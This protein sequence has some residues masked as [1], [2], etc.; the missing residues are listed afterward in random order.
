MQRLVVAP[1][2]PAT[3]DA[4]AE[5]VA[6]AQE[7]DPLAPVTVVVP[8][9]PASVSVR[10]AL[11]RRSRTGLANVRVLALPQLAELLATTA[12]SASGRRPLTSTRSI[13]AV[14]AGLLEASPPLS[15]VPP[16]AAVEEALAATF[17][18]LRDA[19]EPELDALA[20]RSVRAASVVDRFRDHRRRVEGHLDRHDVLALAAAVARA[21]GQVV[22]ELGTVVLHLPRRLG[23]GDLDL[24]GAL[25]EAGRL[26]AVVGVTGDPD[27]DRT[28]DRLRAQ[29]EPLLG[30]PRG[31]D[32]A[33]PRLV[34]VVIESPDPDE[35]A[36]Q[37]VRV[38]LA[39]LESG[40]VDLDRIAIASRV[41]SPY[42]LL[43]HE[44]LAAAGLAHHVDLP[45]SVAQ[46][47]AGRVL[48]GLLDLP[49]HGFRR[50]DVARW[51]RSGPLRWRGRPL[52]P[53]WDVVARRAGVVQGLDQWA[54]RLDHR[55]AE[56]HERV[57]RGWAEADEVAP[58]IQQVDDLQAFMAELGARAGD[59]GRRTWKAWAEWAT[60]ALDDLLVPD[61][62][63]DDERADLDRV[64]E[65]LAALAELDEVEPQPDLGRFRRVLVDEL[66][67]QRR[68]VGRLGQGIQVGDLAGVHGLDLDLL[69]VVGL[70]EGWYPPRQ[71]D[72]PLLPDHEVRDAGLD[73]VLG[74]EDRA[75]ERRDH[76]AALA[77][78][79]Q[80]VL[81]VPR[82]DP[83][84]QRELHRARWL[85]EALTEVPADHLHTSPSFE[86]TTRS[87]ATP[88]D[89]GERDLA[90]LL[91]LRA[92]GT[93]AVATHPVARADPELARGLEAV[94]ARRDRA[95]G[96]WTGQIG[97]H[98]EL[99][100]D[101]RA[102]ASATRLERF[103]WCPFRYLLGNVLGVRAHDD[104]VDAEGI[105]PM[106]RGSL[107]HE[108]LETFFGDALERPPDEPWDEEDRLRLHEIVDR[109]GADYRDAGLTGRDLG[110]GLEAAGI[111][112][113][114][115]VVLDT[116][117]A[118]RA[119]R[120]TRPVAVELHFGD[121]EG[122]NP[123][124]EVAL[125]DGR[126]LRFRGAIDRVDRAADGS[127][128]VVDYKTGRSD[129]YRP[130]DKDPLDR[131]RRL[132]LPIYADAARR[133]L[134]AGPDTEVDAFYWFVE[135][136]GKKAWRG[137][138][139]DADVQR[140]F[141]EVVAVA[142]DAIEEGDFP[143]NPGEEAFFGPTHCGHCDFNRVCP[144]GRVDL[145]EGVRRAPEIER[146]VELAEGE[147]P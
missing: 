138:R 112:R 81:S 34:P 126:S 87:G 46:S 109:I 7:G 26:A 137:G 113:W 143:A 116:D 27:A 98:P 121:D 70:A 85:L 13:A 136:S 80:V 48:L 29:L 91:S 122:G 135:E 62:W 111:R 6:D 44:H 39:H 45:W 108:V 115:G 101:D 2:G 72:D 21:G 105:T 43:L 60:T 127:L 32:R 123:A 12:E 20:T 74:H 22:D 55:R 35:E 88:L 52:P 61:G 142:V 107:V 141:E 129:P 59:A 33:P 53:V 50:A 86:D 4:L 65:R 67:R 41:E 100:F 23:R 102:E 76:L 78:A 30:P 120:G 69:V 131:G 89:R 16:S 128:L 68:R 103:A 63:P 117:A 38:V 145:W 144:T 71:R 94:V 64:R 132:Q 140:R 57:E 42:R 19:T 3:L 110:W 125:P 77:S 133:A 104:P 9:A 92:S 73:D 36:R 119:G 106:N 37:A 118:E 134:G 83:R 11:G 146:Y 90:A 96:E 15:R 8:S 40:S 51:M 17:T 18:R 95:Y 99:R 10:R 25:A 82:S 24:L 14:R 49:E 93:P 54:S 84:G 1:F 79:A 5:L 31:A 28:L 147:A 124:A 114:L 56:L 47:V 139:M 58:R 66:S 97:P 75:D 130:V